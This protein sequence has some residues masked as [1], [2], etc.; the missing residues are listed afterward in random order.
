[1]GFQAHTRGRQRADNTSPRISILASGNF[2]LNP[3]ACDLLRADRLE[4]VEL[5]VEVLF[6]V[7]KNAIGFRAV[8][9]KSAN[10]YPLRSQ[11]TT[12]IR[13]LTGKGFLDRNGVSF[14]A[15]RYYDVVEFG[16]GV[17]GFVLESGDFDA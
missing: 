13:M 8:E 16:E 1:M 14:G 12:S 6:D 17:V 7:D 4:D 10:S 2:S 9:P 11:T 15:P 5:W 3:A